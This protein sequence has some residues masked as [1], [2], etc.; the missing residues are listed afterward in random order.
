[1]SEPAVFGNSANRSRNP[2]ISATNWTHA[3]T[4]YSRQSAAALRRSPWSAEVC[5]ISANQTGAQKSTSTHDLPSL[6]LRLGE[7]LG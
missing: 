7:R 4:A 1:M 5:C 6:Y 2:A 3:K